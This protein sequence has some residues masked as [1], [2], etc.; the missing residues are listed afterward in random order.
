M[1]NKSDS[2]LR[3]DVLD[4][5]GWDPSVNP[6][7]IGVTVSEGVVSLTGTVS[8]YA[9][10]RAAEKAAQRVSGV[11]AVAEEIE[12]RLPGSSKRNDVDI[13]KAVLDAM[14]WHV[15]LPEDKIKVKVE[16]GVVTLS[17]EVEWQF[18]KDRAIQAVRPL[19]GVRSVINLVT[20]RPRVSSVD[21]KA[22]IRKAI[23]RTAMEDAD[24]IDV[25]VQ[26]GVVTLSGNVHT[27]RGKNDAERS[28]WSA[29]GVSKVVNKIT[30]G[31]SVYA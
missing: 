3:Q 23:E 27:W 26:D 14:K 30:V 16:G 22:R 25:S 8:S 17:G 31:M 24:D 2:N 5:L 6:S 12:V 19:T 9:E 20:V 13:A 1:K 10:K 29:P 28:A 21:V 11:K 4:E 15:Y 18:Q 7:D